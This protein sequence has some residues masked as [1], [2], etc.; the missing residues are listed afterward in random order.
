VKKKVGTPPPKTATGARKAAPKAL[1]FSVVCNKPGASG[2]L[3]AVPVTGEYAFTLFGERFAVHNMIGGDMKP[4]P[5]MFAVSHVGL[6]SRVGWCMRTNRKASIEAARAALRELGR[7][8]LKRRIRLTARTQK[9]C[10]LI[11]NAPTGAQR[12]VAR[13]RA[14]GS[15]LLLKRGKKY[16][17][18]L[19]KKGKPRV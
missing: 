17:Q 14:K 3:V 11:R 6:G 9:E 8:G 10:G 19:G 15:P 2:E 18:E 4:T 5:G 7:D 12:P 13:P 1:S 16:P